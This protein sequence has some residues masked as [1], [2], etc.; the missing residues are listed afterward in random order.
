MTGF[1]SYLKDHKLIYCDNLSCVLEQ[2]G[3]CV[4][5][6]AH[7]LNLLAPLRRPMWS[8]LGCR[9]PAIY[10]KVPLNKS[11]EIVDVSIWNYRL[12]SINYR[13]NSHCKNIPKYSTHESCVVSKDL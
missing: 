5:F 7:A 8:G 13:G 9:L 2:N 4:S 11:T 6:L 1:Q 10:R 3:S 12:V